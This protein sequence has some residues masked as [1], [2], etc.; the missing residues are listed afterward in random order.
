[1]LTLQ[2]HLVSKPSKAV[3]ASVI[4]AKFAGVPGTALQFYSHALDLARDGNS[5]AA[6]EELQKAVSAY[7]QFVMAFN[8]MGVQHIRLGEFARAADDLRHALKIDP[9]SIT[10]QLNYGIVLV[11]QKRYKEA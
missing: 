3:K 5:K 2:I 8:E 11:L 7:P 1:A 9:E 4:N 6:L 10:P